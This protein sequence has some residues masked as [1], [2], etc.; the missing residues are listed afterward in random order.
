M[1]PGPERRVQEPA[2]RAARGLSRPSLLLWELLW[3]LS[4]ALGP[5]GAFSRPQAHVRHPRGHG[6][7]L[8]HGADRCFPGSRQ[9]TVSSHNS[10]AHLRTNYVPGH[11]GGATGWTLEALETVPMTR[12]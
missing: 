4:L 5:G 7:P 9:R 2:P 12:E 1:N 8:S 10:P 6:M 3:P 11:D